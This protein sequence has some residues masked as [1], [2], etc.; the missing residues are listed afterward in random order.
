MQVDPHGAGMALISM[1]VVFSVLVMLAIVFT[2][3]GNYFSKH[4]APEITSKKKKKQKVEVA[5]P[6]KNEEE[7]DLELAL[8]TVVVLHKQEKHDEVSGVI[9]I[10]RKDNRLWKRTTIFQ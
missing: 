2:Y 6:A 7:A 1:S 10:E 8:A 4:G 5:V 9:T 3:I